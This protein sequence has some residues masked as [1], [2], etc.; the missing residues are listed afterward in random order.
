MT[1]LLDYNMICLDWF[2]KFEIR[3]LYIKNY[4]Q[5][6]LLYQIYGT[7]SSLIYVF[8]NLLRNPLDKFLFRVLILNFHDFF[9]SIRSLWYFQFSNLLK[10]F[11]FILFFG[12]INSVCVSSFFSCSV[13]RNDFG[14]NF[15]FYIFV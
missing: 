3:D 4:S 6:F 15:A 13:W 2:K 1:N 11:D 14:C 9:F 10:F 12:L 5:F 7:I 8:G